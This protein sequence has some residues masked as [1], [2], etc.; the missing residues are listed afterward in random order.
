MASNPKD[1]DFNNSLAASNTKDC[2]FYSSLH[3]KIWLVP[4]KTVGPLLGTGEYV[5]VL[6]VAFQKFTP[7]HLT[8]GDKIGN[9]RCIRAKPKCTCH[10]PPTLQVR[11]TM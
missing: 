1:R 5:F 7:G 4:Q 2:V 3:R 10:V 9:L 8:F 6:Q 11:P